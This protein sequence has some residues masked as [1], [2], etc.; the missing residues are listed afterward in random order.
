MALAQYGENYTNEQLQEL[1]ETQNRNSQ[2]DRDALQE[3]DVMP[4]DDGDNYGMDD[5]YDGEF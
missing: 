2:E 1:I 5:D 3:G 4:D